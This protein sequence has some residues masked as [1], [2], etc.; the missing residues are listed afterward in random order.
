MCRL[1][2]HAV[3]L[4]YRDECAGKTVQ[5]PATASNGNDNLVWT[6]SLPLGVKLKGNY[7]TSPHELML[8]IQALHTRNVESNFSPC[9]DEDLTDAVRT[10]RLLFVNDLRSLQSS[11]CS[12]AI[13]T[14]GTRSL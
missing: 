6:E 10:M 13:I 7:E 5:A 3:S 4:E 1:L 8:V 9:A 11:V 2:S 14:S 12:F